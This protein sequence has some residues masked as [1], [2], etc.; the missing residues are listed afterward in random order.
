M[1][2]LRRGLLA[3]WPALVLVAVQQVLWPVSAGRWITGVVL[4]GLGALTA[5]GMALVYR[6]THAV[7]FAQ[8]D[9]GMLPATAAVVVMDAEVWGLSYWVAL[10]LGLLVAAAVGA[11]AEL[12]VVRRFATAPRLVLTVATIG[13]SQLLAF[14]ALMVPRIWGLVPT[15]RRVPQPLELRFE[16]GEVVFGFNDVAAAAV[17]PALLAALGWFLTRTDTGIAIRAAAVGADRAAMLGIPVRRLQTQVWAIAGVLG[18]VAVFFTAGITGLPPGSSFTFL[19]LLRAL[20]ALV[21]GRM[22]HL[23]A[24][25]A[26]SVAL[27]LLQ[28]AME[29]SGD[30]AWVGP[31]LLAVILVAL[32]AQRR[33]VSRLAQLT[34]GGVGVGT[35]AEPRPLPPEVAR[36]APVRAARWSAWALVVVVVVGLPHVLDTA[37]TLKAGVVLVFGLVGLSMVVLSGW[38]G[39]VSLGQMTF[40]GAGGALTAWATVERGWDPLV[41]LAAAAVLGGVVAVV[42]G[43]PALRLRGLHLAVSTLALAVAASGAI[44]SGELWR[45]IPTGGFDPPPLAGRWSIESPLRRYHLALAAL[46]VG[47]LVV[48][49]LRRSRVGRALVAQ[50]DNERGAASFGISAT[51][52]KLGA[53][54]TSGALAAVAGSIL[55]LHQG[56]F[57]DDQ[58]S[59]GQSMSVFV[60]AV[61]GGLASPLGAV[62]GALYQRGAQ[63]MLPGDWQVLATGVGV[64]L[65]LL[66]LPD[67]LAGAV[68]RARD[69]V[70][71]GW[72]RRRADA[73]EREA[74]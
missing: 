44:F 13:L 35:T 50:R 41:S 18:F 15:I 33:G 37:S 30:G 59:V 55:V 47:L 14:G 36:L 39:Q 3:T 2:A 58:Y 28:N 21:V 52:A 53:F 1:T 49:G 66:I 31:M 57:I 27:G 32:L 8:A 46:V 56:A 34:G 68:V 60:A 51:A 61:I 67:G 65:M 22:T 20:A 7:S 74:P 40:V 25:A 10:P 63:W 29:R 4:G 24:I 26:T 16:V 12:G 6:A 9:L 69:A 5:V 72:T 73:S 23:G 11:V 45:G 54:A 43:L 64:L 48:R 62:L 19:L 71:A 38:A 70:V 17:A 42:V